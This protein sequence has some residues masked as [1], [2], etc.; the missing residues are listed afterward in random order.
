MN[1]AGT[2]MLYEDWKGYENLY[3]KHHISPVAHDIWLYDV[4]TGQHHQLTTFGGEDRDP[5]W[6]P[7]EQAVYFL[8]ERSGSFNVWKM[9]LNQ[10]DAAVQ[11]THFSR[12]PVRFLSIAQDGTLAFGY[13]GELYRLAPGAAEPQ[14]VAVQIAADTLARDRVLKRYTD[15]ATEIAPSPDGEEVAFVVRGEV[16]VTSTEFGDTKRITDTPTQERSVSFSPD[17]RRLVFAGERD[18]AWNLYEASLPGKK[19]DAP[20]STARRRSRSAPC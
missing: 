18:G 11:V 4:K 20:T 1:R 9:P 8:S 6:S 17:G 5:V 12:N 14:K 2:E 16:F 3:R 15:G 10:P 13:D 19:K 7:D